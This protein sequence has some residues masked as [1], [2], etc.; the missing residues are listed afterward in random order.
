[1]KIRH[2]ILAAATA[3]ATIAHA[4]T[5]LIGTAFTSILEYDTE[6][7]QTAFRGFCA[8]PI[9]SMAV[10]GDTLYLGDDFGSVYT[11]DLNTNLLTGAFPVSVDA[12]AMATDGEVLYIADTT[13]EIQK[14]DPQSGAV[15][16]SLTVPFGSLTSL[17]VHWGYLYHGGLTTIAERASLHDDFDA[18][19]FSLFAVCGGAINSMTFSGLDVFLGATTGDIY[20]YD[21]FQGQF[22]G[23]Y[24]TDV[25]A[26]AMTALTGGRLLIADSSGRLIQTDS[27]TGEVLMETFVGEPIGALLP[28]D[29]GAAC[30]IDLDLSGVLDLGDVQLFIM[31]MIQGRNGADLNGDGVLDIAD[32]NLFISNFAA[33][34]P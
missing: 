9:D 27:R 8:G 30:P 34:C 11:F 19:S 28:L 20:Q 24:Q 26:V 7:G 10:I 21:E 13:G 29:V 22:D 14:V 18:S 25:D 12:A 32:V 23:Y 3:L 6:T 15:L 17:G 31:L 5:V 16:D 2:T 33:G 1:M 4:D